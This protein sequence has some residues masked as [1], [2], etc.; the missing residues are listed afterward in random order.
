MTCLLGWY[1]VAN[2]LEECSVFIF[3]VS[4]FKKT[5]FT[6]RMVLMKTEVLWDVTAC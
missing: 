5:C 3:W 1:A 6:A 2:I 4:H